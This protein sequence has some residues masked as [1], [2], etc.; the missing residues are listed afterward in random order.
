MEAQ[1]IVLV[2][3]VEVEGH[4]AAATRRA[5]GALC[6]ALC[7]ALAAFGIGLVNGGTTAAAQVTGTTTGVVPRPL[8]TD[9]GR[10]MS[11]ENVEAVRDVYRRWSRGDFPA[12]LDVLDPLVSFVVGPGFPDAGT[13]VGLDRVAEYTRGFLEPWSRITIEAEHVTD[14]GD[15]VV[16]AVRQR[17]VGGA[18]GAVTEFRY[19][20]VWSFRGR[21]V[22]RLENF[23]ERDEALQ[24]AG[25]SE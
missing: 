19:F 12:S 8:G 22:I 16:V 5:A 25:L 14:A 2:L 23:R 13:Y 18:S 1:D 15:S 11:R 9:T 21:K 7:L 17:G 4:R 6:F 24:A 3:F 20:Q 10:A